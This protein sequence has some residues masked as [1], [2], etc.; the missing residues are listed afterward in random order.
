MHFCLHRSHLKFAH[1]NRAKIDYPFTWS[2]VLKYLL[3]ADHVSGTLQGVVCAKGR[4][5]D[6]EGMPY[7]CLGELNVGG[8]DGIAKKKTITVSDI[9]QTTWIKSFH[10]L[11]HSQTEEPLDFFFC[12]SPVGFFIE[13]ECRQA[14]HDLFL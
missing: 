8:K 6:S 7:C 14:G 3:S 12:L 11:H 1:W 9:L 2:F 5:Y 4:V 10:T 13:Q